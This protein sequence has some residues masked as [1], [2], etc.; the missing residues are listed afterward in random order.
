VILSSNLAAFLRVIREGESDQTDAAFRRVVYGGYFDSFADHPRI[1]K[2]L[3][4]PHEAVNPHDYPPN[5]TSS[6]AGAFQITETT[7]NDWCKATG[8]HGFTPDE[9]VACAVWRLGLVPGARDAIEAGA[10]VSA[11]RLLMN[12][13]T[14]FARITATHAETVF[15]QYGGSDNNA[16][17][18]SPVPDNNVKV[19][20]APDVAPQPS[21]GFNMGLLLAL[22]PSVLNL[23]APLA[24]EKL[25]K[26]TG[27]PASVVEPFVSSVMAKVQEVTGQSDPVRAVSAL[28]TAPPEKLAAVEQSALDYMD[29]IAPMIDKIA[30]MD[31]ARW[32]ADLASAD[33]AGAR[34]R[35]DRVDIA[36]RL[37]K[38][39]DIAF[40]AAL[41]AVGV[42]L[43]VQTYFSATHTPDGT[44]IGLLT[45]LV[46]A[47]SRVFETPFRYRFGGVHE[48]DATGI[49]GSA[50]ARAQQ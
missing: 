8:P 43:S 28:Q 22:L 4:P 36:P 10:A 48:S 30:E 31:K 5:S 14:S 6:A 11:C 37:I 46:Y 9:Q 29:K 34:G 32:A 15:K 23:F 49:A 18:V 20:P 16:E 38:H 47:V 1:H 24:Q 41:I 50:I 19:V 40:L 44:L 39:S 42:G 45:I 25:G 21:R 33:A 12:V 2:L 35:G 26:L 7:F 13:W 17:V 27:Q 3:T